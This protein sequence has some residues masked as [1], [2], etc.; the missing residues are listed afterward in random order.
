LCSLRCD[1]WAQPIG[2]E[3][4]DGS[5]LS[6]SDDEDD[7]QNSALPPEIYDERMFTSVRPRFSTNQFD[8]DIPDDGQTRQSVFM[9]GTKISTTT[10][11]RDDTSSTVLII[12]SILIA[13]SLIFTVM[14]VRFF[15]KIRNLK[16]E[17][18]QRLPVKHT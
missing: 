15:R 7:E 9:V 13:V 3:E 18:K 11:K 17:C 5:A 14:A 8:G 12:T 10:P 6:D 4:A 1:V 2:D 16:L